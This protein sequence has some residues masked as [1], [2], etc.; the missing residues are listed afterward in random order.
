MMLFCEDSASSGAAAVGTDAVFTAPFV[1]EVSTWASLSPGR[2][3]AP[4][5]WTLLC[6]L[7]INGGN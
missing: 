2:V 4:V 1:R 5:N 3:T 6:K 7:S